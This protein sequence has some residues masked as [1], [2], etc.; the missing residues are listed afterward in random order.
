ML[1][2][3]AE[4]YISPHDVYLYRQEQNEIIKKKHAISNSVLDYSIYN[5][6]NTMSENSGRYM[7]SP[8]S[9]AKHLKLPKLFLV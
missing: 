6:F 5:T 9:H 1:R 7:T 8:T 3:K 2:N 4:L